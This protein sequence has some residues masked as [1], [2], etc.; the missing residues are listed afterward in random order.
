MN[1]NDNDNDQQR[2]RARTT[3]SVVPCCWY[4][5]QP[6]VEVPRDVTHL[7]IGVRQVV[8]AAAQ[9]DSTPEMIR[10][11]GR[12]CFQ[13]PNLEQVQIHVHSVESVP[14]SAFFQCYQLQTVEFVATTTVGSNQ[15]PVPPRLTRI[16]SFAFGSCSNL[17]SVIGLEH[18]SGSLERI[19]DWAFCRCFNL[20]VLDLSCLTRLH[21]WG[22]LNLCR[23]LSLIKVDLYNAVLLEEIGQVAFGHCMAL[24][25]IHLPPNLKRIQRMAFEGC[26]AMAVIV[27]PALVEYMGHKAFQSCTSLTQVTFQSTRHLQRLMNEEQFLG[28][29]ALHTLELQG[30][31][32]MT[33]KLWPLLLEQFLGD[34]RIL[35]RAGIRPEKQRITIAWN[36]LRANIALFY[37]GDKTKPASCRK[38]HTHFSSGDDE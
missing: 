20:N 14:K 17:R 35:V 2:Q 18:L 38:R 9:T 15:R 5:Y 31:P 23:C 22:G 36:F 25:T 1:D 7:R 8:A 32:T 10:L 6:G 13:H 27:I 28:C 34:G 12:L 37:I 21:I 30:P 3:L 16:E 19:Y 11:P 4:D 33:A 29:T 24:K 26:S